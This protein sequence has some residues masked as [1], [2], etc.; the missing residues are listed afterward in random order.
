M[1]DIKVYEEGLLLFVVEY[2]LY[3]FWMKIHVRLGKSAQSFTLYD[4]F[5]R[6][7]PAVWIKIYATFG[8]LTLPQTSG[9]Q[10]NHMYLQCAAGLT[11][12]LEDGGMTTPR[13]VM[14]I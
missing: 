14:F 1:C 2:S 3:V 13:H 10:W 11:I 12:L 7:L 8:M 5:L 6:I 9:R 4:I